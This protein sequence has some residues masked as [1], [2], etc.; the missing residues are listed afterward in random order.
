MTSTAVNTQVYVHEA[1]RLLAGQEET[2][3][4]PDVSLSSDD[5]Q[6]IN[7]EHT[8]PA[9]ILFADD[10]ADMRDYVSR[11]LQNRYTVQTV[12]DGQSALATIKEYHPDLVLADVMM[13]E[14]DGFELL[15]ALRAAP[16]TRTLPV[17]LLSARAGEEAKIEGM[18]AGA[19]DYLI[20]TI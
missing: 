15:Q 18:E 11:L 16:E 6:R 8:P 1:L 14:I 5:R 2:E 3:V 10:N 19:D 13:P 7:G 9:R 4:F 20:Q 17:I 12:P